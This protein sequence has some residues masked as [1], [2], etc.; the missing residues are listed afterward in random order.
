M[1]PDQFAG[2]ARWRAQAQKDFEKKLITTE[3]YALMTYL[4][5]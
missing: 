4:T 5:R 2:T 3:V 1:P